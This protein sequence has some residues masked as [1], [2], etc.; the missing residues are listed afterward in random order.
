MRPRRPIPLAEVELEL[1][2]TGLRSFDGAPEA[3]LST[4]HAVGDWNEIRARLP[5][6]ERRRVADGVTLPGVLTLR[7]HL[8]RGESGAP[9][10]GM[11][12][13]PIVF[14][15]DEVT[16]GFRPPLAGSSDTA[17]SAI[18]GLLDS[19]FQTLRSNGL[20]SRSVAKRL[21][22]FRGRGFEDP[23]ALHDR[24]VGRSSP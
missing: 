17:L 6:G 2:C 10:V 16:M 3:A 13:V 5:D 20:D 21:S 9:V 18:D 22:G 4:V 19:F 23:V 12:A 24:L 8:V 14:D 15:D 7:K 11:E 1:R